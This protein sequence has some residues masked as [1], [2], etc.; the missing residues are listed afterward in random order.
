[1]GKKKTAQPQL[2]FDDSDLLRQ[3]RNFISYYADSNKKSI[4][5]LFKLYN[6]H[7]VKLFFSAIFS[8]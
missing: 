4:M 3:E 8:L 7:Y 5:L 2:H 6:G 1:M